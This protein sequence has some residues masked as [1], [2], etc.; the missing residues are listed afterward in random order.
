MTS[1]YTTHRSPLHANPPVLTFDHFCLNV[2]MLN[3]ALLLRKLLQ[4]VIFNQQ[5]LI[6]LTQ[7][8]YSQFTPL[9]FKKP[10]SL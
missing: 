1:Q 3:Q 6:L 9:L 4:Y 8:V 2:T 7:R 10:L 5:L